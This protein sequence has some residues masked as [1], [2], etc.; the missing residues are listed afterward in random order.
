MVPINHVVIVIKE[1][2]TFDNYFGAFPGAA[3]VAL[4]H[5]ADPHPD[6]GHG[7]D[8]WLAHNGAAGVTG[9][10]KT[11]Y[12][13]A[14][15]PS[16]WALAQQYCLCDNYFTDVASQSEPN[17]LFLIAADSPLID[18]SSASR[19]YQ[20]QPPFDIQSLP[21]TLAAA[22]H[23]WRNYAD[24]NSSYFD[25]IRALQGS[26]WNVP[27]AQ[28]DADVANGFLADVSWLY[29]PFG[30]SEHPGTQ[31]VHQ[32][33][34]WTA[35]RVLEVAKSPLWA[36]TAI[37]ITWDDWGGWYDHV[38]VPRQSNWSGAG[39]AGYHGSQFRYGPRVPCLIV[40]PYAR[41][42]I[43]HTFYSHASVVKFCIRLF[44]LTAWN[45]PALA[46]GDPSGDLFEAFDFA[47]P[48]RLGLPS[49]IPK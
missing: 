36:S 28:F 20:P 23:T 35:Q 42:A 13:A 15:I 37:I 44:S 29:A 9:T 43:N 11:Q 40:S 3:G 27:S 38:G 32:G 47:A 19:T 10:A 6:Q 2:H 1:N 21:Q 14:D 17:H 34:Q 8:A 16:Y 41:N 31:T 5:A 26:K 25:H 18:N 39:P 45:A 22:G 12:L 4:P 33:A 7:H 24:P 30:D 48:P 46:K 49:L